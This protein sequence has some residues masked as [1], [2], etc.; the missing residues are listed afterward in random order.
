MSRREYR[1]IMPYEF[2]LR[3][4]GRS[5]SSSYDFDLEE[6][7]GCGRRSSLDNEDL[8]RAVEANPETNTLTEDLG[9]HRATVVRHLAEIGK[10][11]NRDFRQI[12]F[13]EFK[14][15]RTAAQTAR[16]INEVW[17]Q[18]SVN[19]CTV[20]RWFQKFRAGNTSLEDEQHGSRPPILNND[21]LKATV[22]A[23]PRKTTR[24]MAK[25]LNVDHTT[26]VRH[27]EQIVM[28]KKLDKWVPHELT[29]SQKN[30]RFEISSA[31]LLRNENDP[32]L[33]RIV[34]CDEKWILYDNR[35]RS[36][37]WL[38]Q[39]EARRH[40]PKPKTHQKKIMVTVW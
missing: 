30:R 7:P 29:E 40:H 33:E 5:I 14:V 28:T 20:Q 9:V 36:A 38:D 18:G 19:G 11:S 1:V 25:E 8:E 24:D 35:R 23:D 39:K 21:L 6:Q 26:V 32:F 22:E 34:T 13:Y 37:Q 31:H 10:T 4:S 27:L 16:N 12:Y 15:G 2:Q 17:G 3:L